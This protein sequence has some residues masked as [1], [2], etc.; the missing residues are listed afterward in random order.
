M[1]QVIGRVSSIGW[2]CA[3]SMS[4]ARLIGL[5]PYSHVAQPDEPIFNYKGWNWC[6]QCL[7]KAYIFSEKYLDALAKVEEYEE[8]LSHYCYLCHKKVKT[9]PCKTDSAAPDCVECGVHLV[10]TL[11]ASKAKAGA[12][13][14][15]EAPV[16]TARTQKAKGFCALEA[17]TRE[18]RC[19][20][21][22]NRHIESVLV[23]T[24]DALTK[25]KWGFPLFARPCPMT[26]RHGFV[27]SKL[28][29][30]IEEVKELFRLAKEADPDAEM[31]LQ[32]PIDAPYNAIYVPGMLTIGPGNDGATAGKESV[33]VQ[34]N[35]GDIV[36]GEVK[37]GASITGTSY[38]E[39][40]YSTKQ[41]GE[42]SKSSIYQ[43]SFKLYLTQLRDGPEV[44]TVSMDF[45]PSELTVKE[46]VLAS[47]DLLEWECRTAQLTAG[48]VVYHHGG[49]LA[50]H[51]AV[52]CILHNIPYITS[53]E[54][55]IGETIRPSDNLPKPV[56]IRLWRSGFYS[57]C[58]HA[59]GEFPPLQAARL[60]LMGLHNSS[61]WMGNQDFLL[62]AS[63]GAAFKLA[64]T[65]CF[66]EHRHITKRR[67]KKRHMSR[68]SIYLNCWVSFRRYRYS[69]WKML[70][71]FDT[72]RLWSSG[73]G[74]KCWATVAAASVRL[75]LALESA[76]FALAMRELN[77]LVNTFHN[78]G[79]AFNKVI[80]AEEMDIAANKIGLYTLAHAP[81]LY[82]TLKIA[83]S[84]WKWRALRT[85]E[86]EGVKDV[87]EKTKDGKYTNR[88]R[89]IHCDN[90][91]D[92][93]ICEG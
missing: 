46:V 35:D 68:E 69:L 21:R 44:P 50:S 60:M 37:E 59:N 19:L 70:Q 84:P 14:L 7:I 66:G 9:V 24:E 5:E 38:I 79:W 72:P 18:D 22:F 10:D 75:Y 71:D 78:N 15:I 8:K 85:L 26:P 62:G 47:G 93:C 89:C 61:V 48:T 55:H 49:N 29:W 6:K 51:Y 12:K 52:H 45:I 74:G 58:E 90:L 91:K 81:A 16:S 43:D 11:D 56:N 2:R 63:M 42:L 27:D 87:C 30:N 28:V 25:I 77:L 32:E 13:A 86:R 88:N 1:I 67:G 57:F 53:F 31:M 23:S 64:C 83:H 33:T 80:G 36:P 34:V 92:D 76:N 17:W 54:P 4:P 82:E 3:G 39:A 20:L 73:F 40:V 41:G 65:L